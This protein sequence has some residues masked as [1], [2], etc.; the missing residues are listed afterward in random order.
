MLSIFIHFSNKNIYNKIVYHTNKQ[1]LKE[2]FILGFGYSIAVG[3]TISTIIL[4]CYVYETVK[5]HM[6]NDV[7][8]LKE[9]NDRKKKKEN[10]VEE[11]ED[12]EI[13]YNDNNESS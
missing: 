4:S 2:G 6:N 10:K 7:K 1:L 12:L 3:L 5:M 11:V 8:E 13:N 9:K